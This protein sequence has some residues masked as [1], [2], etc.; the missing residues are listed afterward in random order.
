MRGNSAGPSKPEDGVGVG[1]FGVCAE[2]TENA[3][4]CVA[5]LFDASVTRAT[6]ENCPVCEVDPLNCPV[7][8]KLKPEGRDPEPTDH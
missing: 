1:V 7:L 3:K 2:A 4:L 5:E 8:L 6:N